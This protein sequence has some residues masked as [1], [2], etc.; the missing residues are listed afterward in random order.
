L[1]HRRHH[2][3][4]VGAADVRHRRLYADPAPDP[5]V[6]VVEGRGANL[7][8]RL[9]R[10]R[11]RHGDLLDAN[12][13]GRPKFVEAGGAHRGVWHGSSEGNW[14]YLVTGRGERLQS[15]LR[16]GGRRSMSG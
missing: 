15:V 13:V 2:A 5:E 3:G 9:T 11:R 8:E 7:D 14:K 4:D 12:D 16:A 6:Q 1:P 10:T